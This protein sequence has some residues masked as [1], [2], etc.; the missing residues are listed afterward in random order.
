MPINLV[1]VRHGESE[2]NVANRASRQGDD[3]YFT[4]EF[5]RKHNSRFRLTDLGRQQADTAG[6]FIRNQ[7]EALLP[8]DR[9]YVSEYTRAVETAAHLELPRAQWYIEF[10]LRER[11]WGAMDN[12]PDRERHEAFLSEMQ[13]RERDAFYWAPSG[14]ES[15]ADLCQRIDRVLDTLH[16]ECSDKNII[17][18]CH[19]EVMWAFRVRLERLTQEAY[20][21]L[22]ESEDPKN[23]I[24]NCQILHYTRRDPE[25]RKLGKYLG[26]KRSICP[27]DTRL[28]H[29]SWESITRQRFANNDLLRM[30]NV[31]RQLIY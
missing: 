3:S 19:G 8:F 30:V 17:I 16:R 9:H 1:L 25:T 4:E 15:M 12:M 10:Y 7:M 24:H 21:Q 26:W 29:N 18:V 27:T 14:G 31:V 5:R 22:D 13:R 20:R 28:S 23:R 11:D 2:G 6:R